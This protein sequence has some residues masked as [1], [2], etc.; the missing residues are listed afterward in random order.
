MNSNGTGTHLE[1][2]IE[3]KRRD[4]YIKYNSAHLSYVNLEV[5]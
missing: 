5:F 4:M 1:D 2:A 3:N